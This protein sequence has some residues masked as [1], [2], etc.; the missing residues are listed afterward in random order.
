MRHIVTLEL[1]RNCNKKKVEAIGCWVSHG[2]SNCWGMTDLEWR[3]DKKRNCIIF[4]TTNDKIVGLVKRTLQIGQN[5]M[6][7]SYQ[8]QK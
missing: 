7:V 1:P 6:R 5:L 8:K 2:V 3:F 4:E